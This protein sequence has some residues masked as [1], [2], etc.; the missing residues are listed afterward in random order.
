MKAIARTSPPPRVPTVA[1]PR[2]CAAEKASYT[3]SEQPSNSPAYRTLSKF[4]RAMGA[5]KG[6][7]NVINTPPT[8][9]R[10]TTPIVGDSQTYIIQ[11][12]RQF[13]EDG[14]RRSGGDTVFLEYVDEAVTTRLVLP[15]AV[16]R[17]IARQ[18]DSLTGRAR[19][20]AAKASAADRKARG[21]VPGF[22]RAHENALAGE[23]EG[24]EGRKMRGGV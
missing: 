6:I 17:V 3:M 7:P 5:L 10:A 23:S 22:T 12:Y 15:P 16:T 13:S 14:D 21:I 20:K 11:T 2:H 1:M 9:I 24:A 18:R 8:T 19:S 4:E